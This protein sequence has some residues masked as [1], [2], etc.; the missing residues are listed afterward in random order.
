LIE[1]A[2]ANHVEPYAYLVHVLTKLPYAETVEDLEELL[3]WNF[4]KL[5]LEKINSALY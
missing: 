1:T 2:R 3:P 4:K 5:E